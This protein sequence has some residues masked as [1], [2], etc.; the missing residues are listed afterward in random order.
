MPVCARADTRSELDRAKES[1]QAGATAYAAGDYLAAI[2]ALEAAYELTPLPAIAFSL[3]QAERRQYFVDHGRAH[4]DRAIALFRRY[5]ELA[6][7]GSR[8]PDAL[9]ALSQLEPLAV[10]QPAPSALAGPRVNEAERRTRVLITS[11]APLARLVLDGGP[12]SGSPLIREVT[13]G[14]H[15]VLVEAPGFYPSLRELTAVAGELVGT[16]VPLRERP[17][18]LSLWT[19]ADAEIYVDGTFVSQG[20]EGVT[21]QLA[22]GNHRI[23][24]GQ[25]GHRVAVRDV[26]S[27]RGNAESIRV[28]LE[29]TSQRILSNA[30]F[31][32]GGAAL[33]ASLVASAL[34]VRAEGQ[35]EAFLGRRAQ[36]N[37]TASELYSYNSAIIDRDRY[38]LGT[39]VAL[40]AAGSLFITGLF[41]HELDQPNAQQLFR[42]TSRPGAERSAS[43]GKR[44]V[45]YLQLLPSVSSTELGARIGGMF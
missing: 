7:G 5:V 10:A 4:L 32:A 25:K 42:T 14:K 18:T 2:Q 44:S 15:R 23:A 6:P 9:D 45:S 29:P 30:L 43:A 16:Q 37:V 26:H 20:G 8:R 17:S 3:G 41:L 40:A 34:A 33:G 12:A 35:A 31:I 13:P 27:V 1:F 21:V 11:D 39:T 36:R 19:S 22:S 28:T 24:V 38:R